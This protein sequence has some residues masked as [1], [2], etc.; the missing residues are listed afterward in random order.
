MHIYVTLITPII[1]VG[2]INCCSTDLEIANLC[3]C[4]VNRSSNF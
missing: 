1:S 3:F 2:A 4:F